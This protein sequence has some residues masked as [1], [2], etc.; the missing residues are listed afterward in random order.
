MM[1]TMQVK[2]G[3]KRLCGLFGI[4]R[5]AWYDHQQRRDAALINEGKVLEIVRTTRKAN[6]GLN[7]ISAKVLYLIVK[8]ELERNEVNLGRDKFFEV[9]RKN[10]MVPKR[11]RFRPRTTFSDVNL[12]LFPNLAEGMEITGPEQLWVADI[13][14]LWVNGRFAYLSLITDA[15]SHKVVGYCLSATLETAGCLVALEM[16]LAGRMYPG[17]P[18]VHHSDRGF[19]YRSQAYLKACKGMKTSM[20]QNGDP[21][22][23]AIAERMNG[24]LKV[25]MELAS[26]EYES[27][28]Q[29]E[30]F[31]KATIR[32]YNEVKPHSSVDNLTPAKAH[33]QSGPLR[34]RWKTKK[35]EVVVD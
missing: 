33:Q 31:T 26:R 13:T 20:T 32:T 17:S 6:T 12:P 18:L 14:Y 8:L 24:I 22:E 3:L 4:T 5:Q 34:N 16:A 9:L 27:F 21:R 15:Y 29:A 19:Q 25:D 1:K 28:A 30:E 35:K 11:K 7:K 2:A 10:G 23:N